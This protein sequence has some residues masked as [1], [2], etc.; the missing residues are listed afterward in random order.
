MPR[1][2]IQTSIDILGEYTDGKILSFH[3]ENSREAEMLR[4]MLIIT[5]TM[6]ADNSIHNYDPE[7]YP[8]LFEWIEETGMAR[9]Q[10]PLVEG[11]TIP[12]KAMKA[13][14]EQ[15]LQNI[16][17]FSEA[18]ITHGTKQA[19]EKFTPCH[20][21]E[22]AELVK[23]ILA[24]LAAS[25]DHNRS[26]TEIADSMFIRRGGENSPAGVVIPL[27]VLEMICEEEGKSIPRCAI[28]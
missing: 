26:E 6:T 23:K 14:L 11:N 17:D 22:E 13:N 5:F 18:E 24:A 4:K 9:L 8:V 19:N 21:E 2:I 3:S 10:L 1:P 7:A 20:S 16:L 12:A 27:H 28:R 15:L 25:H